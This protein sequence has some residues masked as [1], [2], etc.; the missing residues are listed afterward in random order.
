MEKNSCFSSLHVFSHLK[1]SS[2]TVKNKVKSY[3]VREISSIF[4]GGYLP[5][6]LMNDLQDEIIDL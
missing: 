2:S 5:Y 1:A 3:K 4:P 6:F